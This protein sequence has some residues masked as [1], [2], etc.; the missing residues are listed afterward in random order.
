M[1]KFKENEITQYYYKG[2]ED[3]YD[4]I[5]Q[6][7][8]KYYHKRA[9]TCKYFYYSFNIIKIALAASIPVLQMLRVVSDHPVILAIV[10]AA[11]VVIE[12]ILVM[13][14]SVEKWSL[15]R[16]NCNRLL[17]IQRVNAIECANHNKLTDEKRAYIQEVESVIDDEARRWYQ[18][19][20]KQKE[21]S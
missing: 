13:T 19:T 9:R 11:I 3:D 15:F 4:K 18:L 10:S 17:Q 8:I 2:Y 21:E 1:E 6:S 5:V 14:R 12:S 7:Y 16:N 20:H